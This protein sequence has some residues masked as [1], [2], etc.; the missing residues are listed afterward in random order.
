MDDIEFEKFW[1]TYPRKKAKGDAYKA[2]IQTEKKRPPLH[3]IV[4][5][6]IALKASSDW[7]RDGGQY[8]PYPASWLRAWGWADAPDVDAAD[9]VKGKMWF[10][11]VSG[12]EAK[13]QELGLTWDT[14][15]GETYAQFRKRVMAAAQSSKVVPIK[16]ETA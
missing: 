6:L 3:E 12:I 9:I 14:V 8:V 4:S 2:W 1:E 5:A 15:A 7:R 11:T 10:D 13:A 16:Q